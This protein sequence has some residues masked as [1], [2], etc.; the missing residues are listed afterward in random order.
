MR[1][2]PKRA[3]LISIGLSLCGLAHAG[4]QTN[5]MTNI[6][7]LADACDIVAVGVD[8]GIQ[9]ASIPA[10]G[11]T[12]ATPNT[13][14]GNLISGNTGHP[15]AAV[16]GGVGNDDTLSL[17][18]GIGVLDTAITTVLSTVVQA[19]PGVYVAC[20]TAPTAITL[21]SS[22]SGATTYNLPTALASSPSGTFSGTLA[23]VGGGATAANTIDYSMSFIGTP[24][25]TDPGGLGLVTLFVGGFTA[26][27][28]ISGSQSGTIVPGFYADAAVAQV[29]F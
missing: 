1:N 16:D 23:G 3:L 26:T 11:I 15:N 25:N 12:S 22:A 2:S 13:A 20:T 17:T 27:G 21:T 19:L 6:V 28:T 29:D 18:T 7:T 5:T 9:A 10:A 24:V 8:F 14:A 4:S